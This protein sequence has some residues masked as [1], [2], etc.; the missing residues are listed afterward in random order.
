MSARD[1]AYKHGQ[2]RA[3]Q[4]Y[5]PP[6]QGNNS[7]SVHQSAVAGWRDGKKK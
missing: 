4:G 6:K 2:D 5:G 1:S 7:Q 3:R